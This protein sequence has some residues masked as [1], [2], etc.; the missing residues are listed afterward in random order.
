MDNPSISPNVTG[1][2]IIAH[3][4][5]AQIIQQHRITFIP[6]F[7][8]PW[9]RRIFN[10]AGETEHRRSPV[11]EERE[12]V[13]RDGVFFYNPIF[14]GDWD[15]CV[16]FCQILLQQTTF[17]ESVPYY[18]DCYGNGVLLDD[19]GDCVSGTIESSHRTCAKWGGQRSPYAGHL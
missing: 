17:H 12:R 9:R 11:E 5:P 7:D 2:P 8:P 10:C 1:D 19:V 15:R 18:V 4:I 14:L 13:R 3:H 6:S 16:A